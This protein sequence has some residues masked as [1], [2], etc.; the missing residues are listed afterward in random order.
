LIVN[1]VV[2]TP[3]IEAATFTEEVQ[4]LVLESFQVT[5]R[6]G[7]RRPSGLSQ[8]AFIE[9]DALCAPER[10]ASYVGPTQRTPHSHSEPDINDL[11]DR[12]WQLARATLVLHLATDEFRDVARSMVDLREEQSSC[13]SDYGSSQ[14]TEDLSHPVLL[15]ERI[16]MPWRDWK[17]APVEFSEEFTLPSGMEVT[18]DFTLRSGTSPVEYEVSLRG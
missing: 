2:T 9:P 7:E 18:L 15:T 1:H 8:G 14:V 5:R 17:T 4:V 6:T 16:V 12:G 11:R 3:K 10:L 13:T